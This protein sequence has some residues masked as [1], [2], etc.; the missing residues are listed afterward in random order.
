MIEADPISAPHLRP[1]LATFLGWTGAIAAISTATLPWHAAVASI[2]LGALMIAGADVDARTYLLPDTVTWGAV[3]SGLLAALALN[4]L[5]PMLGFE[6]AVAR[7]VG[8]ALAMALL[9]W[10]YVS[11]R[12]EEGLGMGD[13]K[14][15]AG[16]GAWL[17][18]DVMPLCFSLAAIG[19]L[20]TVVLARFRGRAI[21][22]NTK[23]PL[24]AFLCPALWFV[25]YLFE[26]RDYS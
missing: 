12:G 11:L 24:G 4:P 8:T 5:D 6:S 25:F 20:I 21:Y 10:S 23:I 9:R 18:L 2:I 7:A 16:V 17:P 22:R 1:D 19:A 15:S 14:L 26:L 13:I 3:G